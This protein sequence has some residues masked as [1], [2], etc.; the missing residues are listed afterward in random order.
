MGSVTPQPGPSSGGPPGGL[1]HG[2]DRAGCRPCQ[3]LSSHLTPNRRGQEKTQ[4]RGEPV[5]GEGGLLPAESPPPP[6]LGRGH[7]GLV[8]RGPFSATLAAAGVPAASSG[9]GRDLP[10]LGRRKVGVM[11]LG[12]GRTQ[13][14]WRWDRKCHRLGHQV[15]EVPEKAPGATCSEAR[16][17]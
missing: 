10:R 14:R 16:T 8:G 5:P 2:E 1:G 12:G 13:R 17:N 3:T 9:E 4:A 15:Q 6:R 7:P 11:D